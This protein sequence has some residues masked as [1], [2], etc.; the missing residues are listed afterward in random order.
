MNNTTTTKDTNMNNWQELASNEDLGKVA[1][2]GMRLMLADDWNE[3][4]AKFQG[5]VQRVTKV[6]LDE[7]ERRGL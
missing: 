6:A 1:N 7:M 5:Q 3:Q 4:D 2:H